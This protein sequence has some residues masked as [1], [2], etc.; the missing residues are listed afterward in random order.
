MSAN[1]HLGMIHLGALEKCFLNAPSSHKPI[2]LSI[3][4]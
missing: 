4:T 2:L 3:N 1:D